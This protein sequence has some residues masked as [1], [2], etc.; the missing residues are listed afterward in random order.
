MTL[1]LKAHTWPKVILALLLAGTQTDAFADAASTAVPAREDMQ[2]LAGRAEHWLLAALTA[3]GSAGDESVSVQAGQLDARTQLSKCRQPVRIDFAPGQG[4]RAKTNLSLLCPDSPGWRLFLPMTI[5][6]RTQVWVARNSIASGSALQAPQWQR[7]M[8]DVASL[9]AS[10]ITSP[11]LSG[12]QARMPIAA[13]AV[14]TQAL[15]TGKTVVKRGQT[16][17]LQASQGGIVISV[18]VEAVDDGAA[19]ERIRVRNLSSG[20]VIDA[21]VVNSEQV[22]AV[23]VPAP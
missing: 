22:N 1:T 8:R 14:L 19:G 13:G 21:V 6:R 11:D 23:L 5:T 18:T 20:R 15:V 17:S 7:E 16:L 9:P 3:A 4:L 2:I 12:Y 10:A